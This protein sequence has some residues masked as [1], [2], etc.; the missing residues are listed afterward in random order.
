MQ[1]GCNEIQNQVRSINSW[2]FRKFTMSPV[3]KVASGTLDKKSY[4]VSEWLTYSLQEMYDRD[5]E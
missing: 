5:S 2:Q 1:G 4:F 3:I